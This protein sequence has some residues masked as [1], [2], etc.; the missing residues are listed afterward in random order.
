ME[1]T[2]TH[3]YISP[4]AQEFLDKLKE[5]NLVRYASEAAAEMGFTS[6]EE[7]NDSIKRTIELCINAGIPVDGNF[8]R[9]Y[10]CSDQG[11]AYDWKLSLLAYGL[12][13]INGWPSNPRV[14]QMQIGLLKN[15]S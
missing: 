3:T 6:D 11:I 12:V 14:A 5:L 7:L 1:L 13:C 8:Q 2:T 15:I 9:I 10:M 4:G